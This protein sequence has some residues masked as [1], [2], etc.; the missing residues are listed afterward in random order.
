MPTRFKSQVSYQ[1]EL[2]AAAVRRVKDFEHLT[3]PET[4]AHQL[5]AEYFRNN[6]YFVPSIPRENL[7]LSSISEVDYLKNS[8]YHV[9]VLNAISD[10]ML[11]GIRL[12]AKDAF[13]TLSEMQREIVALDTEVEEKE[14]ELLGNYSNVHL[15]TF[16]RQIDGSLQYS[17]KSW[18]KDFKTE[19]PFLEKYLMNIMPAQGATLPIKSIVKIP[20]T[21]AYILNEKTDVGDALV[22]VESSS[23]RNLFRKNKVFKHVIM[24]KEFDETSRKFK[25][26][27]SFSDYPY[28][29]ISTCTIQLEL[30]NNVML[31]Y[32]KLMPLGDSTVSVK[33]LSYINESGEEIALNTLAIPT[34]TE[35]IFLFAPIHTKYLTITLEQYG[36]VGRTTFTVGDGRAA[37]LNKILSAAGWTYRINDTSWEISGRAYDFSLKD[38][39]VGFIAYEN[40]GI[41]RS[42]PMKVNSPLGLDVAKTVESIVA[43]Q[44]FG[45]YSE[46]V[47]LPE[48]K[49]LQEAYIGVRLWDRDGNTRVDSIVPVKDENLYQMEYLSAIGSEAR[50]KLFPDL[51]WTSNYACVN[52]AYTVDLC[53]D[54]TSGIFYELDDTGADIQLFETM[55]AEDIKQEEMRFMAVEGQTEGQFNLQRP[56]SEQYDLYEMQKLGWDNALRGGLGIGRQEDVS[57]TM[58]FEIDDNFLEDYYLYVTHREPP[59]GADQLRDRIKRFPLNYLD[60]DINRAFM[61]KKINRNSIRTGQKARRQIYIPVRRGLLQGKLSKDSYG[62]VKATIIREKPSTIAKQEFSINLEMVKQELSYNKLSKNFSPGAAREINRRSKMNESVGTVTRAKIKLQKT[63]QELEALGTDDESYKK[64]ILPKLKDFMTASNNLGNQILTSG[65][66]GYFLNKN[67]AVERILDPS[68]KYWNSHFQAARSKGKLPPSGSQVKEVRKDKKS[69]VLNRGGRKLNLAYAGSHQKKIDVQLTEAR[70]N[71]KPI[72]GQSQNIQ[73]ENKLR[74]DRKFT[75]T[76]TKDIKD[77][78]NKFDKTSDH[79]FERT[80]R[81]V[82][83][84]ATSKGRFKLCE[85]NNGV[86]HKNALYRGGFMYRKMGD[87]K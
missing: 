35:T 38:A 22:P 59:V 49:A 86:D 82:Y 21:D 74:F 14:I 73:M 57:I 43:V 4:V 64:A 52:D 80:A 5:G 71:A 24:R 84:V 6:G 37:A 55:S 41:F 72:K 63:H 13:A 48:G 20:I 30:P 36:T 17:D 44:S 16:T 65:R 56:G 53:T 9:S 51:R 27:T 32:F 28:S 1:G 46:L 79:Y 10:R 78:I 70:R 47:T 2:L 66:F 31:N 85:S 7:P 68:G 75:G 60:L 76:K 12:D 11:R 26:E 77:F 3:I 42:L 29:C 33:E 69:L 23:P 83:E 54:G 39:E 61:G 87:L 40:K 81:F 15:N 8:K 18:I 45:T 67:G 34:H 25:T 50:V 19:Y 62:L 58:K